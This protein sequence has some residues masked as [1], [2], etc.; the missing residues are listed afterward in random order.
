MAKIININN[1]II[2]I[3]TDNGGIEEVRADDL[4]FVPH[5]GDE[6]EIFKTETKIIVSKVEPKKSAIS[7]GG[8]NINLSNTQQSNTQNGSTQP[9][10]VAPNGKVVNKLVYCILAFFLGGIGIHKFYA[11]QSGAGI[12]CLLFSWTFIPAF[13]ALIDFIVGLT[14]KADAN[15]NI[16][17]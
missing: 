15:G 1:Q 10:V 7:E 11:G 2:S 12:A 4:N 17:I 3:G 16:I 14:K 5:I 9:V 8:I 6:V 13:I